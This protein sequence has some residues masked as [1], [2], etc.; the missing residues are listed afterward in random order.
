L[1][2]EDIPQEIAPLLR[3]SIVFYLSV[4]E[5]MGIL[6]SLQTIPWRAFVY[7]GHQGE[8]VEEAQDFLRPLVSHERR[9]VTA[10][11]IRLRDAVSDARPV[12]VLINRI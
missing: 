11:Y 4:R 6:Q 1:L 9:M 10:S 2:E 12:V 8:T 5:H 7:E 3:E